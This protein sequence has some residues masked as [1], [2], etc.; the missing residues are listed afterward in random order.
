MKDPYSILGVSSDASKEDIK[1]AYKK[2]ALEWHPDR[3]KT[4]KAIAEE[5]FK[6]INE[7][8]NLLKD[9]KYNAFNPF[10]RNDF[11][12]INDLFN[13][14]FNPFRKTKEKNTTMSISMEEAHKGC[15]KKVHLK[16]VHICTKCKGTGAEITKEPCKICN[17]SGQIKTFIATGNIYIARTCRVCKGYGHALGNVCNSCNGTGKKETS[18]E[19]IITIPPGILHGQTIYHSKSNLSIT[20]IYSP[21]KIFKLI[22]NNT[23]QIASNV[24]INMFDAMLGSS[25]EIDTLNGKKVLK[26][27]AGT[28]P[29]SIMCIKN[30]GIG[31]RANH[32]VNVEVL[33]LKN[34]T[35]EQ[36]ELLK[37]LKQT[38]E[39]NQW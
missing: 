29:N 13:S 16:E 37:K 39:S 24:T 23:G 20:I 28:Q 2:L 6:E 18:S 15:Q 11:F 34:L 8:Y 9:G 7:A 32:L 35:N 25:V 19:L 36:T 38:Q 22:D 26:I 10:M 27:K 3:H 31:G 14:A 21:H 33:L 12:D 1:K 4:N 5:H 30:G 17:G